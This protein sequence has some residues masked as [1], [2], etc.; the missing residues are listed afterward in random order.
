[1]KTTGENG[2]EGKFIPWNEVA[3]KLNM[4]ASAKTDEE[5]EEEQLDKRAQA[6]ELNKTVPDN[7][8]LQVPIFGEEGQYDTYKFIRA[9][10][11]D[12]EVVIMALNPEGEEVTLAPEQ[13]S[14][15]QGYVEAAAA[16]EAATEQNEPQI[17]DDAPVKAEEPAE[18]EQIFDDP[19]ANELG[20][21][22]D[23]LTVTK[24]G[25]RVVNSNALWAAN[26]ALL[27]QYNDKTNVLG[28]NTV[29]YLTEKVDQVDKEI[30]KQEALLKKE[31]LGAN[32]EDRKED[33]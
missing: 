2:E 33:I 26:P 10:I 27:A 11:D 5:L 23:F 15:L 29:E 14:N 20:I 19:I 12:G 18:K 7:A 21:S 22:K 31:V 25:R 28:M 17:E 13:I 8:D 24:K 30:S 3:A 1:M 9:D 6:T 32:D 16:E 4:P